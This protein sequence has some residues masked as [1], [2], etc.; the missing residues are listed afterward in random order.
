MYNIASSGFYTQ[1]TCIC[2][3]SDAFA[4]M[5]YLTISVWPL[6]D[7]NVKALDPYWN[8]KTNMELFH[9]TAYV[10]TKEHSWWHIYNNIL[11]N[12]SKLDV[13]HNM[14]S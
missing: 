14:A 8:E 12:I 1:Y 10:S 9:V 5:R 6:S 4:F 13:M 7:A 11:G 3:S 2:K